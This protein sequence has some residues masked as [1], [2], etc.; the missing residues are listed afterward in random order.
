MNWEDGTLK[1]QWNKSAWVLV[2]AL[3]CSLIGAGAQ[4]GVTKSAQAEQVEAIG[5]RQRMPSDKE[6][7][8][9]IDRSQRNQS[10]SVRKKQAG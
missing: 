9:S 3:A 8:T 1:S 5:E 7:P 2:P 10:K 6:L 4:A